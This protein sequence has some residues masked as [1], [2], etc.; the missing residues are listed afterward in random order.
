MKPLTE[1]LFINELGNP[2]FIQIE[3]G[4]LRLPRDGALPQDMQ[5][6]RIIRIIGK[7]TKSENEITVREADELLIALGDAR[8]LVQRTGAQ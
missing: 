1:R 7:D 2:V 5:P 3:A 8:R 6:T 4:E